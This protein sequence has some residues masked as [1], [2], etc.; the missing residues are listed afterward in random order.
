ML[1]DLESFRACATRDETFRH[2]DVATIGD[3]VDH[4]LGAA[5]PRLLA[6]RLGVVFACLFELRLG[7]VELPAQFGD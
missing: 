7:L 1:I 4:A 5:I 6:L 3:D 2:F